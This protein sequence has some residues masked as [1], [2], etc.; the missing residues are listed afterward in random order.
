MRLTRLALVPVLNHRRRAVEGLSVDFLVLNVLGF[1]AYALYNIMLFCPTSIR[2]A[3]IDVHE[4]PPAVHCNDVVF[5][6]HALLLTAASL[7]Q[8][9]TYAPG[10]LRVRT[11]TL[12][13]CGLSAIGVLAAGARGPLLLVDV[14][15]AIKIAASLIKYV[16][17]IAENRSRSSTGGFS[18]SQVVLDATGSVLSISQLLLDAFVLHSWRL[19][20]NPAKLLLGVISLLYD[21]LLTYQHISYGGHDDID[22]PLL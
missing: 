19:F 7:G 18:F 5:S 6:L 17:Q 21:G 2:N 3:Y 9:A 11:A 20:V 22:E 10:R 1:I 4:T 13:F 14:L 12:V 8:A 16:P 15:S